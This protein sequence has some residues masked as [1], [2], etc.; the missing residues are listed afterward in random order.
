MLSCAKNICKC[1]REPPNMKKVLFLTWSDYFCT[2]PHGWATAHK[3][4]WAGA[5]CAP[6]WLWAVGNG[7]TVTYR[8]R[9]LLV[10]IRYTGKIQFQWELKR[11][12]RLP[13]LKGDAASPSG[14]VIQPLGYKSTKSC[15]HWRVL[16][17]YSKLIQTYSSVRFSILP[18]TRN[19]WE[20]VIFQMICIVAKYPNQASLIV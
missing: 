19:S 14:H 12:H 20:S 1:Q 8:N 9:L 3:Q 2:K 17:S 7:S 15:S 13:W 4:H 16:P 11:E 10:S 6:P 18:Y 5:G